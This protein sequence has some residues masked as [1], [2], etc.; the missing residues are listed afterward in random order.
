MVP[1]RLPLEWSSKGKRNHTHVRSPVK[2]TA[3]QRPI[4]LELYHPQPQSQNASSINQLLKISTSDRCLAFLSVAY[5]PYLHHP[6]ANAKQK[7]DLHLSTSPSC[8]LITSQSQAF[9]NLSS[10][11]LE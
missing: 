9:T 6:S 4:R 5:L 7:G 10:P 3:T 8:N 1:L 2:R 11:P